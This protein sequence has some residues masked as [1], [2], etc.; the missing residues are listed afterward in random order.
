[1]SKV[2]RV[3]DD[4]VKLLMMLRASEYLTVT[5]IVY[6]LLQFYTSTYDVMRLA[7]IN[8]LFDVLSN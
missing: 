1:M 3:N 6:D 5:S 8:C 7:D 2:M 4:E